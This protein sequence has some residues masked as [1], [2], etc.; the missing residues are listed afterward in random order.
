MKKIIK[1][2]LSFIISFSLFPNLQKEVNASVNYVTASRT[3]EKVT[4]STNEEM[5]VTLNIQGTPPLNIVKPNDV[6]LVLDKSGSMTI[7]NRINAAKDAAK[8][9]VDLMDLNQHRVGVIGFSDYAGKYNLNSD[10]IATKSYIDTIQASGSTNTGGAIT[11][12]INMLSNHRPEAQPVIVLLTDGEANSYDYA[13][14]QAQAAKDAGIVFYT[15]ALLGA[16]DNPE[17]SGP[18]SLL[19]E[20]ATTSHHHHFVLGSAGLSEIYEAI[21]EEIGIASAYDVEVK[22]TVAPNFE[23]VPGSYDN[24]IPKPT[25]VGNVLTWNF[26]ELKNEPLT[27]KYKVRAKKDV[28]VGTYPVTETLSMTYKDYTGVN[29]TYSV[30]S[31]NVT[32]KYPAPIINSVE[33]NKGSIDGGNKVTIKGDFFRPGLTV[34]FN[35]NLASDVQVVSTNEIIATAPP[36]TQGAATITV[37]NDDGQS[38]TSSYHYFAQP[39]VS[40]ISPGN[41]PFTGGNTI[42]IKGNY[43]LH[44]IKIKVGEQNATVDYRN[45]TEIRAIIPPAIMEGSVDVHLENPDLTNVTVNDGY[46]YDPPIKDELSIS[47]VSPNQGLTT[48]GELVYIDGKKFKEGLEVFFGEKKADISVFYSDTRIRVIAPT[49]EEG[50]VP[51]TINNADGETVRMDNA[52]TYNKPPLLPAPQ[53]KSITPDSGLVTGGELVILEGSNFTENMK[54]SFGNMETVVNYFYSPTKVRVKVPATLV[55]GAV[56]VSVT[57]PDAQTATLIN[58]YTYLEL[59]PP[60]APEII[61]VSPNSGNLSGGELVYIDGKNFV[62]GLKVYFGEKEAAMSTFYS[63]IRF[64]VVAPESLDAG[65]VN[66][67]IVNPDGQETILTDGYT[68]LAPPPPPAPELTAISPNTGLASGGEVIYIDGK[69]IDSKAT[70]MFGLKSTDINYYYSS[71]RI[72]VIAPNSD[73]YIGSV[74]ITVTNPDGQTFT[75]PQSYTYTLV[76]PKITNIT[77]N[78]GALIGGELVYIDGE[79]FDPNFTVTIGGRIITD[80]TYYSSKR[81][82]IKIPAGDAPGQVPI[83]VTN[84]DGQTATTTYTYNSPP[85]K[86]A[87]TITKLSA[88]SGPLSG[89]NLVYIDGSGFDPNM[90]ID[91]GGIKIRPNYYYNTTRFRIK[92]PASSVGVKNIQIINPDGQ[93]SNILTYEYK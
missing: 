88:L 31:S 63:D 30:P 2:L 36:G 49:N 20:M 75:L 24:N 29:R 9:F 12:A 34:K 13:K 61:K 33:D 7:D 77:P 52:Y 43:F 14:Q 10:A 65:V 32:L 41:G 74:D 53:L 89:G 46:N 69:N 6:V 16:N 73:G 78:N 54:I 59:P 80:I 45:P 8:G 85:A 58:G 84:P 90:E 79:H 21:V 87:P 91:I 39:V 48:G 11:E 23:I 86:P 51:I 3:L 35:T 68:Y 19:K 62:N 37:R 38:V 64:R 17:T 25:V 57:L 67:K 15:I 55:A 42:I 92:M 1:I 70:I 18:N 76:V 26:I 44:G 72:R 40:S 82:R 50:V 83:I 27:F 28:K 71:D 81:F 56:D 4:M 22:E 93:V 66:V 5:E 60:P 47:T